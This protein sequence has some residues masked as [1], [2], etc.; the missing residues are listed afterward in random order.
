[1]HTKILKLKEKEEGRGYDNNYI[2]SGYYHSSDWHDG[3][4][5][6]T[7]VQILFYKKFTVRQNL[8]T[9]I[10]T[11]AM[12]TFKQIAFMRFFFLF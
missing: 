3:A 4:L 2:N 9:T 5:T 11:L 7:P 1:M 10:N 6:V 12:L 8:F